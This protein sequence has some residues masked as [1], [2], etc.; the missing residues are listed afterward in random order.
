[1]AGLISSSLPN[2][3]KFEGI[4][5]KFKK[6]MLTKGR[7]AAM[8]DGHTCVGVYFLSEFKKVRVLFLPKVVTL[9]ESGVVRTVL[10]GS[11]AD[12]TRMVKSAYVDQDVAANFLAIVEK[13]LDKSHFVAGTPFKKGDHVLL[14][15]FT[16]KKD[17]DY[18]LL[19]IPVGYL[20][21]YGIPLCVGKLVEQTVYDCLRAID[22]DGAT[23]ITYVD[24]M[25]S[26]LQAVFSGVVSEDL[27][28]VLPSPTKSKKWASTAHLKINTPTEAL[29]ELW[30]DDLERLDTAVANAKSRNLAAAEEAAKGK[31]TENAVEVSDDLTINS[32]RPLA[33]VVIPRKATGLGLSSSSRPAASRDAASLASLANLSGEESRRSRLSILF[34]AKCPVRNILI[35][36]IFSDEGEDIITGSSSA[37]RNNALLSSFLTK[38]EEMA[39]ELHFL[40]RAVEPPSRFDPLTLSYLIECI[41]RQQPLARLT[42]ATEKKGV[43]LASFIPDSGKNSSRE[44]IDDERAAE[45][46]L[47]EASEHLT[48]LSTAISVNT[49]LNRPSNAL[50]FLANIALYVR[51]F[52]SIDDSQPPPQLYQNAVEMATLITSS[53]ARDMLRRD[54]DTASYLSYWVYATME[55]F[56]VQMAKQ[57]RISGALRQAASGSFDKIPITFFDFGSRAF[58]MGITAFEMAT[59]GGAALPEPT[60]YKNSEA[61]KA[62]EDKKLR[63]HAKELGALLRSDTDRNRKFRD[64]PSGPPNPDKKSRLTQPMP[65]KQGCILYT[66]A[67]KDMPLPHFINKSDRSCA[68]YLRDGHLCNSGERCVFGHRGIDAMKPHVQQLWKNHV[69]NTPDMHF[70]PECVKLS[71]CKEVTDAKKALLGTPPAAKVQP[72][73]AK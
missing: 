60:V 47:G 25:D 53:A 19:Q 16:T 12:Q 63:D 13:S 36:P 56:F 44:A 41:L 66:G 49:A 35:P 50:T 45:E 69:I 1:L 32:V 27:K 40:F 18:V 3:E 73:A 2:H 54:P 5:K 23:W 34:S 37:Y 38:E 59:A 67:S 21:P 64:P 65:S 61:K 48:K 57:C 72:A 68:A 14:D 20:I 33:N 24:A 51:T 52:C 42:D 7:L 28:K 62:K 30:A 11:A 43:T 22:D 10:L 4:L 39:D 31:D 9:T 70:N 17:V 26:Q 29:E 6:N 58:T 55:S 71:L 8:C 15:P 46:L